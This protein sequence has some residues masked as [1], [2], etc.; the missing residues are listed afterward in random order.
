M[1]NGA[2]QTLYHVLVKEKCKGRMLKLIGEDSTDMPA[3][4]SKK[5]TE[6]KLGHRT[7]KRREQQLNEMTGKDK[8]AK[9]Y[10]LG[11][12]LHLMND[13]E[14]GLPIA[15]TVRTAEVHDSRPFF[16]LFP[17]TIDNFD[18]QERAKFCGDSA[19]DEVDIRQIIRNWRNMKDVIAIN[20]RGHYPSETPKDKDYGKRWLLEQ[21]NSVLE[22]VYGLTV[23]RMRGFKKNAVHAFSCLIANF[24]EHFM[25]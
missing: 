5:D 14:T 7:Q 24:I 25:N 8:K 1:E 6:A 18:I 20:G 22:G 15:A 13:L 10:V 9:A 19:F 12:K 17:Y 21:T 23:N 2:I 16:E 4:Y 3:F 11:Y